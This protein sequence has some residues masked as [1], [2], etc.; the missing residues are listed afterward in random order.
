MLLI[1]GQSPLS[2]DAVTRGAYLAAAAGCDSCHTDSERGGPAYAGGRRLATE[3]GV[4]TTP[5]ITPDRASG[6]GRWSVAD[7]T[8]AMRWGI[9]PDDSHYVPAFPFPFYSRLTDSDLADLKAFLDNLPPVSRPGL[10]GAGSMALLARARAAVAVAAM[11]PAGAWRDDPAKGPEWNRGA[12]LVATVGR[13]GDC[14]TPRTPL[15]TPDPH[16]FLAGAPDRA[17]GKKAPNITPDRKAGIG[18]WSE[19]DIVTLLTDGSTP[20]FDE[21]GG[22]M[23]EIVKNT[24][25][26]SAAD[27]RAIVTFLQSVA[28]VSTLEQK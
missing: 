3:F 7:F 22:G 27:R 15:G 25:R 6:I 13:C 11:A 8:R 24:A 10:A 14:H 23:A 26:L 17:G 9:A 5:N 21:V 12:Y 2:A 1:G 16:R 20:N 28:A 4:L 18:N 19:A